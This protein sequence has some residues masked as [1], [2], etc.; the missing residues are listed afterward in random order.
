MIKA[1]IFDLWGTIV[2]NGVNPSP[3]KQVRYFLRT[4]MPFSEFI[5]TFEDSFMR[6][7][8]PSLKEG[9]E[10]VVKDFGLT[11][12]DFVYDK[13]VGMWNKNAILSEMYPETEEVL[14]A[15]KK[16]KIKLF[17][18]CNIDKFAFEQVNQKYGLDKYFNKMYNSYETGKLKSDK[19][20]YLKILKDN[21][22]KPEQVVVVGDCLISDIASAENAGLKGILVDRRETREFELKV[23]SLEDLHP[24]IEKL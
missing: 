23:R 9:F 14:K 12:P 5:T 7:E 16:K 10:N 24:L 3:S 13:L 11:L 20:A 19:E 17:L 4:R 15:L 2:E 6:K 21:K 1:L 8:F 22:L 18:L